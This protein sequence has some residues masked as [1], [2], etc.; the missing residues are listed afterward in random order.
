MGGIPD[1]EAKPAK[2]RRKRTLHWSEAGSVNRN[3]EWGR[4]LSF[5]G[6]NNHC[7]W[8]GISTESIFGNR[9]VTPENA[10][11]LLHKLNLLSDEDYNRVKERNT[12]TKNQK[13]CLDDTNSPTTELAGS[14]E[15][16]GLKDNQ[17][18][19]VSENNEPKRRLSLKETTASAQTEIEFSVPSSL[20]KN[21]TIKLWTKPLSFIQSSTRIIATNQLQAMHWIR[22][23][24]HLPVRH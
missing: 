19:P 5:T 1:R 18:K 8:T 15:S 6:R 23:S 20:I 7:W 21:Q 11:E 10:H 9:Q 4:P 2:T 3:T 22:P 24:P 12:S 14:G 16:K 17:P 13:D